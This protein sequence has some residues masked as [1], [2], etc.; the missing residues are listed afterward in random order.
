MVKTNPS[1]LK[2]KYKLLSEKLDRELLKISFKENKENIV[3]LPDLIKKQ[4]V[5]MVIKYKENAYLR[6]SVALNL[7]KA[8]KYFK[9]K[10]FTLELESAYRSI[11]EQK[12][13][14]ISR[15]ASIK[16]KYPNKPK[17]ELLKLA[18]TYT[19]GILILAAHTAGAAVDVLLK[20]WKNSSLD[21]GTDYLNG[22]EKSVTDYPNLSKKVKANRK[23]LK[24]GMEKFGFTNYPFEY[25]H[26]SI[27]DVFAAYFNKQKYAK[28][29]P[30]NYDMKKNITIFS[31]NKKDLYK[32]FKIR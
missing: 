19:A 27:G 6:E 16:K 23:I 15:Y 28:Y 4:N 8:A 32:F 10:N 14:F 11:N 22:D 7:I 3:Y 31:N 2:E 25:W 24:K 29:G 1:H 18:N 17:S 5:E 21:F 26:Y 12:K 20:D 9:N 30:V 13:R